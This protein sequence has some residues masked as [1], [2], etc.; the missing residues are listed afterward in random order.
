MIRVPM[1]P[2]FKTGGVIPDDLK[3]GGNLISLPDGTKVIPND[4]AKEMI[5]KNDKKYDCIVSVN[6]IELGKTNFNEIR[7][8]K[9]S[10]KL[11]NIKEDL[12]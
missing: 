5:K 6:G 4:L 10:D 7:V 3:G 2:K 8:E 12:K 11:K 9:I 1:P